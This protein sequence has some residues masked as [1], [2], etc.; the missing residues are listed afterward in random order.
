MN[1]DDWSLFQMKVKEKLGFLPY[2]LDTD[3]YLDNAKESLFLLSMRKSV[4]SR[5]SLTIFSNTV[6]ALRWKTCSVFCTENAGLRAQIKLPSK[7]RGC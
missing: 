4:P 3:S 1:L 5:S 2:P 7:S 6:L